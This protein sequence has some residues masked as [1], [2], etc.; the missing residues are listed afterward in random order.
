MPAPHREAVR[1]T[2]HADAELARAGRLWRALER[3]TVSS[4]RTLVFTHFPAAALTLGLAWLVWFRFDGA[5]RSTGAAAGVLL[6]FL[7]LPLSMRI[8]LRTSMYGIPLGAFAALE[9]SLK[10]RGSAHE[11]RWCGAPLSVNARAVFARCIYCGTDSLVLLDSRRRRVH[12]AEIA[13]AKKHAAETLLLAEARSQEAE[14]LSTSGVWL[15]GIAGV[16]GFIGCATVDPLGKLEAVLASIFFTT[17]FA[18]GLLAWFTAS[19]PHIMRQLGGTLEEAL[20]TRRGGGRGAKSREAVELLVWG[21]A[22]ALIQ[23]FAWV[24]FLY[25]DQPRAAGWLALTSL[26]P[27]LGWTL[28]ALSRWKTGIGFVMNAELVEKVSEVPS[29][30]VPRAAASAEPIERTLDVGRH[31]LYFLK[32]EHGG[33]LV[34]DD[35]W[36]VPAGPARAARTV[37]ESSDHEYLLVGTEPSAEAR[38]PR[39]LWIIDA[40]SYRYHQLTTDSVPLET[41]EV[42]AD[43]L[44]LPNAE[45]VLRYDELSFIRCSRR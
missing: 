18:T 35:G 27:M 2:K 29:R 44:R 15:A 9:Q 21:I 7:V 28:R 20:A 36:Y 8:A 30:D 42:H 26:V 37:L 23:T 33:G 39:G 25:I 3:A 43:G 11:C 10:S 40:R 31:R 45:R 4:T 34:V 19:S 6:M 14:L 22:V 1:L 5:P 17:C 16:T 41:V 12:V 32:A 24:T 38:S 13:T